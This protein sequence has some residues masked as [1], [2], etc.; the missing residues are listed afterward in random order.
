MSG[1]PPG[2]DEV[3]VRTPD[4]HFLSALI[5]NDVGSLMYMHGEVGDCLIS[6]NPRYEGSPEATIEYYL[7]N[8]QRD[9]YPASWALPVADVRLALEHLEREGRLPP[10]IHWHER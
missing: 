5:N 1:L 6:R 8:G 2:F 10:F 4:G 9:C 3:H 7:R